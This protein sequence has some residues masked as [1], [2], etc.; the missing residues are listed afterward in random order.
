[1]AESVAYGVAYG[2]DDS[3]G[4]FNA[5]CSGYETDVSIEAFVAEGR[6]DDYEA[7]GGESHVALTY[8]PGAGEIKIYLNGSLGQTISGSGSISDAHPNERELRFGGRQ[9]SAS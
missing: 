4:C 3:F 7:V 2:Q 9:L 1:M 6:Y 8:D 5:V